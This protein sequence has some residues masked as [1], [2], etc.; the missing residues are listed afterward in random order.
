MY[1]EWCNYTCV[2]VCITAV[3]GAGVAEYCTPSTRAV[4][5]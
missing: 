5:M 1:G 2:Q 3:S 4:Y